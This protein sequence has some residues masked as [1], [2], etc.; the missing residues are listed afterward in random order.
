MKGQKI[1]DIPKFTAS[2]NGYQQFLCRD[3]ATWDFHVYCEL[4]RKTLEPEVQ[5]L[6]DEDDL[7]KNKLFTNAVK[8]VIDPVI[9]SL[10]IQ[11]QA[12]RRLLEV[13]GVPED[14]DSKPHSS[15]E[16]ELLEV[17]SKMVKSDSD[18]TAPNQKMIDFLSDLLPVQCASP[19]DIE[20]ITNAIQMEKGFYDKAKLQLMCKKA[21]IAFPANLNNKLHSKPVTTLIENLATAIMQEKNRWDSAFIFTPIFQ[22]QKGAHFFNIF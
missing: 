19:A 17:N 5:K 7:K 2:G 21:N 11:N 13:Q 4:F 15:F 20:A 6:I 16:K 8:E 9:S 22:F 12:L 18:S 14:V 10:E 1:H 3:K